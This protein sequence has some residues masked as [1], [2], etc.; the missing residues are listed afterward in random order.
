MQ[1]ISDELRVCSL[2]K[3]RATASQSSTE[4]CNP[5]VLQGLGTFAEERMQWSSCQLQ[6]SISFAVD[7]RTDQQLSRFTCIA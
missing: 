5:C 2:S 3:S 4:K 6:S 7:L 1:C